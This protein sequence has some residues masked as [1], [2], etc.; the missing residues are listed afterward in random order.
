MDPHGRGEA[1]QQGRVKR[2]YERLGKLLESMDPERIEALEEYLDAQEKQESG[3]KAKDA[4][5]E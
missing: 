3:E 2:L 1:D 4:A 5:P